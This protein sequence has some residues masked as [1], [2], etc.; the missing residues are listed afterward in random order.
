MS[1]LRYLEQ[2]KNMSDNT[3]VKFIP[4][5]YRDLISDIF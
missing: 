2:F 1:Q 5:N 3:V 4:W